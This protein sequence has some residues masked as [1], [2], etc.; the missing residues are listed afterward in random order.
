MSNND[1]NQLQQNKINA[2]SVV[3]LIEGV[4]TLLFL[5]LIYAWSIFRGPLAE[6]FPSWTATQVSMTFTIS[7]V[8]FCFGGFTAGKISNKVSHRIVLFTSAVLII[9]GFSLISFLLNADASARSLIVLYIFYG[10]FCGF[11][12]GLSYNTLLGVVLRH[13]PGRAGMASG[14]LL[15]GFGIGGLLLGGIVSKLVDLYDINRTFLILGI[16]LAVILI[17]AS[18]LV[19]KP[20]IVATTSGEKAPE[21]TG[22]TLMQ[23]ISKPT[24]WML[25]CW[26][27]AINIGGLLIINSAVPI[28]VRFGMIA[29]MGLV[30]SVFNGIGRPLIGMLLDKFGRK[31]T[32]MLNS[33]LLL[34][35]GG[36]LLLGAMTGNAIFIYIGLPLV[37]ISYG[38]S[39]TMLSAVINNF[40]GPKFYQVILGFA[41]FSLAV[42]AIVGPLL[43]SKLQEA[44]GGEYTTSFIMLMVVGVIAI[45]FSA[46]M[47]IF[48]RKE[49]LEK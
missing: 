16:L 37:G 29:I 33:F 7:I 28:A 9:I 5:G 31:G 13:F 20:A 32:M 18:F 40:Y 38:G 34:I 10:V 22:R 1:K 44:S 23:A 48:S 8:C 14:I 19:K 45:I 49:G 6:M 36:V 30:V 47:S 26:G 3:C 24:F 12:V 46:L 39:P 21:L 41:T 43:S 35:A 11:A 4:I 42:S 2:S 25:F 15:L 17:L 27:I